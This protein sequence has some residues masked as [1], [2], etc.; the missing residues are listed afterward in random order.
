MLDERVSDAF[1]DTVKIRQSKQGASGFDERSGSF[2]ACPVFSEYIEH[3]RP[4]DYVKS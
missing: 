2:E 1:R 4:K 3:V